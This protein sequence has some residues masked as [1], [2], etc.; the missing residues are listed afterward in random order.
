MCN[1][2]LSLINAP[3]YITL[4][5]D[6][7]QVIIEPIMLTKISVTIRLETLNDSGSVIH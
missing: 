4:S 6:K 2:D 1:Y 5:S 7:K 3:K